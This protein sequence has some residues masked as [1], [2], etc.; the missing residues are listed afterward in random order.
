MLFVASLHDG[1]PPP[2]KMPPPSTLSGFF[3]ARCLAQ[4][5]ALEHV[6]Y[7]MRPRFRACAHFLARELKKTNV[8]FL[9]REY[10][11]VSWFLK[12]S[13]LSHGILVPGAV[14]FFVASY[15]TWSIYIRVNFSG[16]PWTY[17]E[18]SSR[19]PDWTHLGI[20]ISHSSFGTYKLHTY[21]LK[22][23]HSGL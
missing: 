13:Y 4:C 5:A 10:H 15:W 11:E 12:W 21:L 2:R 17:P 23:V 20:L 6:R 16:D 18:F 19:Y 1:K 8:L 3:P 7:G 9:A 14:L 22:L